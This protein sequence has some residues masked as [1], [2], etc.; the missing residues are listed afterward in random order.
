M[1]HIGKRHRKLA[2]EAQLHVGR[3]Q[4]R[5]QKIIPVPKAIVDIAEVE[6]QFMVHPP[7]KRAPKA[8]ARYLRR[9]LAERRNAIVLGDFNIR[10]RAVLRL[11]GYRVHSA[12]VIHVAVP[13]WIPSI[14]FTVDIGSDHLAV[15]VTLWP[16]EA[17]R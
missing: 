12:G 5:S 6:R 1:R 14:G 15:D 2:D 7:P 10:H 16:S 3:R 8:Q 4:L 11:L 9:L 17:Q 13:R